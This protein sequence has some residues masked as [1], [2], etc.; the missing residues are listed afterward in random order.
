ML[1]TNFFCLILT[2]MQPM[3]SNRRAQEFIIMQIIPLIT[4]CVFS[5]SQ[6]WCVRVRV[7]IVCRCLHN[8]LEI[9]ADCSPL[10]RE[11]TYPHVVIVRFQKGHFQIVLQ[12]Y[13]KTISRSHFW[14]IQDAQT[15]D[16]P[17][18]TR[19]CR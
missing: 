12:N 2:Y 16:L 6:N 17:K 3:Y 18:L 4:S 14:L 10:G 15:K 11:L 5:K 8:V 1:A 13:S 19:D 7:E 9:Q